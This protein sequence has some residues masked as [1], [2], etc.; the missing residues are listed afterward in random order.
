MKTHVA[1]RRAQVALADSYERL[2]AAG[3]AARRPRAHGRPRHAIAAAG[4]PGQPRAAEGPGARLSDDDREDLQSAIESAEEIDRMVNDLLD[5]SRLEAGQDAA[6][7]GGMGPDPD[8]RRGARGAGG[9]GPS[10]TIDVDSA[11]AVDVTLRRR[12]RPPGHGEPGQQ[13]H[14]AHAGR[15][16]AA[17][18]DRRAATARVSRCTTRGAACLRK[19]GRRSSRS[20]EPSSADRT[21]LPLRRARPRVLQARHRGPRRNHRRRCPACPLAA[22][23]GSSCRADSPASG[24]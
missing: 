14:Q 2:R 20:S 1:L 22:R 10:S 4:A 11:G 15:H 23:S 7:A 9:H 6:R 12:A 17:H 13:R 8:G 5:V 24:T 3:A 16:P 18:L 19:P 21:S